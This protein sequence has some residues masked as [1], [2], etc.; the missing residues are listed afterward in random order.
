[1]SLVSRLVLLSASFILLAAPLAAWAK[2]AEHPTSVA[3]GSR[4]MVDS[5]NAGHLHL[6][7]EGGREGESHLYYLQSD[8]RGAIWSNAIDITP[9]Q[10]TAE[11]GSVAAGKGLAVD[12]VWN[13]IKRGAKKE[14]PAICFARSSDGGFTFSK[15]RAIFDGACKNTGPSIALA[16]DGTIHLVWCEVNG[17]SGENQIYYSCSGDNGVTWLAKQLLSLGKHKEGVTVA[18]QPTVAVSDDGMVHVSWVDMEPDKNVPDIFYNQCENGKWEKAVDVSHSERISQQPIVAVGREKTVFVTWLD[19]SRKELA[20]D[21]WCSLNHH[22]E[23]FSPAFNISDTPGVSA[24]PAIATDKRGRVVIVWSDTTSGV[25]KPDIFGRIS[26]DSMSEMSN[27]IDFSNTDGRSR[28]PSAAIA[29]DR[30]FVVW[31]ED[32]DNG[33]EIMMKS[34][35]LVGV[36]TGPTPFVDPEIRGIPSNSR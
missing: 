6:V 1:M 33:S 11:H 3:V 15:P 31:E 36:A 2:Q 28:R 30:V 16:P 34:M 23:K 25:A 14:R 20:P 32:I 7:F 21:I 26:L 5:D 24:D 22:D 27:L 10:S 19:N 35:S 8:S 12:I 13:G 4:P 17:G 18:S 9:E 29:G